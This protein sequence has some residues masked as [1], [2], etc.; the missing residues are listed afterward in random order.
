MIIQ[1]VPRPR[2]DTD[3]FRAV[4]DPTRRQLLDRLAAGGESMMKLAECFELS[5]PVD[6][7]YN[8]L[9]SVRLFEQK[10]CELR[11]LIDSDLP[12]RDAQVVTNLLEER[13]SR[14]L[15]TSQSPPRSRPR[16]GAP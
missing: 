16:R 10:F 2:A 3:V 7:N 4:A 15:A 6:K 13:E 12:P 1:F 11:L 5:L 14:R 9:A 8:R